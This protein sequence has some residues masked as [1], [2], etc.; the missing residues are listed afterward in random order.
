VPLFRKQPP[1]PINPKVTL[2]G[3]M[4]NPNFGKLSYEKVGT[5]LEITFSILMPR[6][7]EGWQTGVALDASSSM[8]GLYGGRIV[9]DIPAHI[10]REYARKKWLR[11]EQKDG[12]RIIVFDSPAYD[13]ALAK[14]YLSWTENLIQPESRKFVQY[15][16]EHLDGDGGTTVIYW[17]CGDGK[18]IEVL[19]D[20]LAQDCPTLRVEGPQSH[21]YGQGTYLLPALQYFINR[22]A[23]APNGIYIFITD[24]CLEDLPAVKVYCTEL[25]TRI[26]SGQQP[27]VK[28]ILIGMGSQIDL[29]PLQELDDL[30]TGT[31]V[32]L[33]DYKIAKDMRQVTEI[34]AELVDESVIVAPIANIYDDQGHLLRQFTDGLPARVSFSMPQA[35]RFFELEI[36][37]QTERI[38]QSIGEARL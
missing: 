19:G 16:A 8:K 35:S 36:V 3:A 14:G 22:F 15:L 26:Q 27:P 37:G 20:V 38:R 1:L 28:C 21:E 25:A 30:E 18:E 6:I 31:G 33:W 4:L 7:G 13:D 9:G 5:H 12:D 10:Q 17:G 24:G 11:K 2:P 34:F 32:D 29:T 23:D